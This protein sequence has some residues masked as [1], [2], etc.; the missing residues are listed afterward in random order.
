MSVEQLKKE[1]GCICDKICAKLNICGQTA[2]Q[3]L[4]FILVSSALIIMHCLMAKYFCMCK[5]I[6]TVCRTAYNSNSCGGKT[7]GNF[8]RNFFAVRR[9]VASADHCNSFGKRFKRPVIIKNRRR[10][11]VKPARRRP[12]GGFCR[13]T[14]SHPV[15]RSR[16]NDIKYDKNDN[17]CKRFI[18]KT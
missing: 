2:S 11:R 14:L 15:K 16:R 17:V 10:R 5:C 7:F 1:T 6:D 3:N 9:I 12:H 8:R 4:P 18:Y 13:D